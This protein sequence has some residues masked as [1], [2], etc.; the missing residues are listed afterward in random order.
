M[1]INFKKLNEQ[2]ITKS[3]PPLAVDE[4]MDALAG[5]NYFSTLDLEGGY[6]QV[7]LD[8][9][10]RPLTAFTTPLGKFHYKTM[11]FGLKNA[12][13]HFQ[14][15]MYVV[16]QKQINKTFIVYMDDIVVFSKDL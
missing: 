11:P 6:H 3:C 9:N 12:P 14:N 1:C 7:F 8:V 10:S 16:L 13:S 2:T 4:C 15:L 5:N